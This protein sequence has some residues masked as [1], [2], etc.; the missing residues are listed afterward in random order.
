MQTSKNNIELQLSAISKKAAK[1]QTSQTQLAAVN[2]NEAFSQ[3]T[4]AALTDLIMANNLSA[5]NVMTLSKRTVNKHT[6]DL[7][8]MKKEYEILRD[9]GT[10]VMVG[11]A[12]RAMKEH[13][14]LKF[15]QQQFD[16]VHSRFSPI[17]SSL[18]SVWS[19]IFIIAVTAGLS[20]LWLSKA[21]G[22]DFLGGNFYLSV[23]LGL[24]LMILIDSVAIVLVTA[25]FSI[26][27]AMIDNHTIAITIQHSA[28]GVF[29]V[30]AILSL[31]V[32]VL[33]RMWNI[34]L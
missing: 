25:L 7:L 16:I 18:G 24:L 19:L 8:R 13:R 31:S 27:H 12:F 28:I 9:T 2:T 21:Y 1:F 3:S 33:S 14:V 5:T 29:V 23:G 4:K 11:D 30:C 26:V 17:L 20:L 34:T 6:Q 10:W 32:F 22:L 15:E